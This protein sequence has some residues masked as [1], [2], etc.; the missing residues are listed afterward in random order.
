MPSKTCPWLN[1]Q[2]G[3]R[4]LMQVSKIVIGVNLA[5]T[6]SVALTGQAKASEKTLDFLKSSLK[7]LSAS[8]A[9]SLKQAPAK[10]KAAKPNPRSMAKYSSAKSVAVRSSINLE[11]LKKIKFD[12]TKKLPTRH[13]LALKAQKAKMD[14]MRRHQTSLSASVKTYSPFYLSSEVQSTIQAPKAK[15]AMKRQN[16]NQVKRSIQKA[17]NIVA[18]SVSQARPVSVQHHNPVIPGQVGH[19]CASIHSMDMNSFNNHSKMHTGSEIA[20]SMHSQ[21]ERIAPP[22][23]TAQQQAELAKM[24]RVLFLKNKLNQKSIHSPLD[25]KLSARQ[26]VD[27]AYS[28]NGPPPFPLNL[29]PEPAM[30]DFLSRAR[31]R[32]SMI[33]SYP[34]AFARKKSNLSHSGF[35]S[36][37]KT[38]GHGGFTSYSKSATNFSHHYSRSS[39]YSHNHHPKTHIHHKTKHVSHK[40]SLGSQNVIHKAHARAATY[41]PYKVSTGFRGL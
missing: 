13:E 8:P 36:Y 29:V 22:Q 10:A 41:G 5:A 24:A 11:S 27:R 4:V 37:A 34:S 23:M 18:K 32:K 7:E 39:G 40:V 21:Q 17:A 12:P 38:L 9:K 31:N 33:K 3:S 15:R 26:R 28:K 6:L 35:H 20:K 25:S 30:K 16:R 19:P 14:E 2:A 1:N